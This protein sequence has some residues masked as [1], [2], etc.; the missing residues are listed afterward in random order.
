MRCAVVVFMGKM[1]VFRVLKNTYIRLHH[2]SVAEDKVTNEPA[3]RHIQKCVSSALLVFYIAT[4][5]AATVTALCSSK[6]KRTKTSAQDAKT[7]NDHAGTVP[8]GRGY[9]TV[10]RHSAYVRGSV[11]VA[12]RLNSL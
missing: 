12:R 6:S 1:V 4:V 8:V 3:P 2:Y 7:E 5:R 11:T 10:Y 9:G